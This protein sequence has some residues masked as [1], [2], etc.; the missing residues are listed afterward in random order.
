MAEDEGG[1]WTIIIRDLNERLLI[2]EEKLTM[3]NQLL[4]DKTLFTTAETD[5]VTAQ[6]TS[7]STVFADY[8]TT[9][10]TITSIPTTPFSSG[11][12][13][14]KTYTDAELTAFGLMKNVPEQPYIEEGVTKFVSVDAMGTIIDIHL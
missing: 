7:H 13:I 3:W 10:P 11:I 8:S 14:W 9:M 5:Q 6:Q 1:I 12:I 4:T 2:A